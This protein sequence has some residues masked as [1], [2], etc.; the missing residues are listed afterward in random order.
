MFVSTN[1]RRFNN[2]MAM[3][4][5]DLRYVSSNTGERVDRRL[6]EGAVRI[7]NYIILSMRNTERAGHYYIRGRKKHYPSK[8]G[9]A[10]AIDSGNLLKS[11]QF[12]ANNYEM[13]IGS[14]I[15]R[16]PYPKWLEEGTKR[17]KK[18]PWL[19][20]AVDAEEPRLLRRLS[21][22][23]PEAINQRFRP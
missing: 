14:V 18:R 16:P 13:T 19:A 10:P 23:I 20:P 21:T 8:E 9:S 4:A 12:D 3:I 5:R 15:D 6:K 1:L 17:M 2:K 7:R 22:V 11:I